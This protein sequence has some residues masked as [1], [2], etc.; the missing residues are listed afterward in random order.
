M[1]IYEFKLSIP[2]PLIGFQLLE[3][4]NPVVVIAIPHTLHIRVRFRSSREFSVNIPGIPGIEVLKNY[5]EEFL[6]KLAELLEL[7]K[8]FSID[9]IVSCRGIDLNSIPLISL[10]T[11]ITTSIL[12]TISGLRDRELLKYI[13]TV[14]LAVDKSL[15]LDQN[16]LYGL[17]YSSISGKSVICRYG[18][19]CI[20]LKKSIAIE[21]KSIESIDVDSHIIDIRSVIGD[22]GIASALT[23]LLGISTLRFGVDSS[24][25]STLL[26]LVLYLECFL[27][28]HNIYGQSIR[29]PF[30]PNTYIKCLRDIDNKLKIW[31]LR[32]ES[33]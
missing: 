13:D 17:R 19:G 32:I 30:E 16:L 22:I 9:L 2:F 31:F 25:N 28:L 14:S 4:L 24:I 10:Y 20:E 21:F 26:R 7:R 1:S 12:S 33:L 23:K 5:I 29:I 8:K 15:N 11:V 3:V 18:E 6:E 27:Q